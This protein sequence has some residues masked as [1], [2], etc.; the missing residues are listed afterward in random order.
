[1]AYSPDA[2]QLAVVA[3]DGRLRLVDV[4]EER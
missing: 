4:A 3:E 1:M 2:T